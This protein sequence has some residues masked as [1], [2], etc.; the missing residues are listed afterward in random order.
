MLRFWLILSLVLFPVVNSFNN[1]VT[2][3]SLDALLQDL[4]LRAL[5][6]RRPH[7]DGLYKA[8]LPEN[9]EGIKMVVVRIWSKTLWSRGA[10]FSYIHIPRK[11]L[12]VPYVRRISLV[13]LDFGNWSSYFDKVKGYSLVS[14][15][16]GFMAFDASNISSN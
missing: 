15:V 13:Y 11:T 8:D 7:T 4:A 9:L 6:H 2:N 16:V 3:E 12:P 10:N 14:S 5:P 1:P